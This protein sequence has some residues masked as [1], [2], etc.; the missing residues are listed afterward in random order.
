VTPAPAHGSYS[1]ARAHE[2]RERYI[3]LFGGSEIPVPVTSIAEDLCGLRIETAE[4]DCSGMLLPAQRLIQLSVNERPQADSPLRRFRFTIAHELG[5]W[6][7][8]AHQGTSAPPNFCRHSD[9][10]MISDRA[11]EREANIFAA[12]LLMPEPNVRAEWRRTGD[13]E[14][15]ADLFDVSL[16]AMSWRLYSFDLAARPAGAATEAS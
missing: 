16:S 8:H 4:I 15:L 2:L 5:H 13:P 9:I 14:V 7:C 6:V 3:A 10:E 12:E 1:D 11:I